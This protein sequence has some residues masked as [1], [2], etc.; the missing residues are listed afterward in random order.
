MQ[1]SPEQI[2]QDLRERIE[3]QE[4]LKDLRAVLSHAYGKNFIRYLFKEFSVGDFPLTQG[5]DNGFLMES[6]GY[7]KAGNAIFKIVSE[8]SPELA[9]QIL[10]QI[11]KEKHVQKYDDQIQQ[12]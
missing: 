4:I 1:R 7:F 12:G 5:I 3:H 2:Q 10:A 8:A 9:G 6:L 11:E